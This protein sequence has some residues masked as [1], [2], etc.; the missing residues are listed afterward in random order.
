[1]RP[2]KQRGLGS[3]GSPTR[4]VSGTAEMLPTEFNVQAVPTRLK[5]CSSQK[6]FQLFEQLLKYVTVPGE[7]VL[8]QFAG[9]GSV[10]IACQRTD[11]V[12]ARNIV[13]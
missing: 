6:P 9:S 1:M 2:D 3:E 5:V 13:V 12:Q 7:I 8:D 4:F 11:R 10:G